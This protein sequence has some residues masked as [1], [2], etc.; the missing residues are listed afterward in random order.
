MLLANI[1]KNEFTYWVTL[2]YTLG[3]Q[4]MNSMIKL[5]NKEFES[6]QFEIRKGVDE[7]QGFTIYS[8]VSL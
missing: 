5:L 6:L 7:R 8:L 4:E 1:K 2:K 3:E